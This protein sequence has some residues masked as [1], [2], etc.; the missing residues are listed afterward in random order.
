MLRSVGGDSR[1]VVH[2]VNLSLHDGVI[3]AFFSF[4]GGVV[5]ESGWQK[6]APN[7][8]PARADG[9]TIRRSQVI[10]DR[11]VPAYEHQ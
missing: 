8:M 5:L 4:Y 1:A 10:N 11:P 7:L 6:E 3:D 2:A 9:S